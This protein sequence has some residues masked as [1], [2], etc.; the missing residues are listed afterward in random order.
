M[1]RKDFMS[2]HGTGGF[3]TLKGFGSRLVRSVIESPNGG[4]ETDDWLNY[5]VK[6]GVTGWKK[7]LSFE[8][9]Y[10]YQQKDVAGGAH[11]LYRMIVTRQKGL[12]IECVVYGRTN[13]DVWNAAYAELHKKG[14]M[15]TDAYTDFL[16]SQ[17]P[18]E[19]E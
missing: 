18:I 7:G 2:E 11:H 15:P 19:V 6:E 1:T 16:A 13:Q 14:V 10:A 12:A 5:Q 3:H 4:H 9:T 8:R 17:E